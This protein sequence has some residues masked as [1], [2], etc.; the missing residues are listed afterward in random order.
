MVTVHHDFSD[1]NAIINNDSRK[2]ND[3]QYLNLQSTQIY[4]NTH[5]YTTLI[6]LQGSS[7]STLCIHNY[8]VGNVF[9]LICDVPSM[10]SQTFIN[11]IRFV[12]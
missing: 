1:Q 5:P 2:H 10:F 4:L 9:F 8:V 6:R 11:E 12:C 3:V 7:H